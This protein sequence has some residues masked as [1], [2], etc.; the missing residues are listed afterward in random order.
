MQD[1]LCRST[2]LMRLRL[3]PSNQKLSKNSSRSISSQVC[4][5]VTENILE[6]LIPRPD[7]LW[8]R[9]SSSVCSVGL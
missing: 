7:K 4:W 3:H 9:G 1:N 5:S 2:Y 8:T 6:K